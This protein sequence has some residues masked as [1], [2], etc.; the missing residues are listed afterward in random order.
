[1]RNDQ[2]GVVG[3]RRRAWPAA[4]RTTALIVT[5]GL[6]LLAS[7]C[8][9]PSSGVAAISTTTSSSS[10]SA[11][12]A[13]ALPNRT[14]A[15]S[16]CMRSNGVLSFPDPNSA[17][18]I[19]KVALQRLGVS[20]SRF[21]SAQSACQHL[22]PN[23]GSGPDQAQLQQSRTQALRFS[24]CVRAHGVTNFP[25][26]DNTGRIPDPAT[27]GPP[28]NQGAPRFQAA[29]RAC[30]KYRPPYFPSNA[31]YNAYARTNGS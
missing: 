25:D 1:M 21:E 8:G 10:A 2:T 17:G 7:A 24:R 6:A 19:P 29:N 22:L 3:S 16:R 14:L 18:V 26:P 13:S 15:F 4:A 20:S 27:L 5:S 23:G 9:P 11:P 28:I 30:G 12:A 31:A